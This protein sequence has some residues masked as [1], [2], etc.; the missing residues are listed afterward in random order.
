M[1]SPSCS[2]FLLYAVKR[3]MTDYIGIDAVIFGIGSHGIGIV[4]D[5]LRIDDGNG[6]FPSL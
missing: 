1:D 6:D 5:S 4:S 3:I 2:R